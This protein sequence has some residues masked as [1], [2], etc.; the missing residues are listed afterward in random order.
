VSRVVDSGAGDDLHA[1]AKRIA[2]LARAIGPVCAWPRDRH[3]EKHDRDPGDLDCDQRLVQEGN[4]PDG[5]QRGLEQKQH[6][7]KARPF[8]A[9]RERDRVWYGWGE[10]TL[11]RLRVLHQE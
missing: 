8:S 6:D 3:A 10:L 5:R 7:A 4:A 2:E 11:A 9:A 1:N